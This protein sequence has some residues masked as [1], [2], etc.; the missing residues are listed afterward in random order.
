MYIY[1]D[2]KAERFKQQPTSFPVGAARQQSALE[3]LDAP[4]PAAKNVFDQID[5]VPDAP[6]ARKPLSLEEAD[7]LAP[8]T[9]PAF[10][11]QAP[12]PADPALEEM[13][14]GNDIAEDRL[15]FEQLHTPSSLDNYVDS[16]QRSDLIWLQSLQAADLHRIREIYE[17][18]STPP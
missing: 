7:R 8:A 4:T 18:H 13:R 17:Q 3:F 14:R 10:Q 6:A 5:F 11:Y 16:Q 1:N 2:S 9:P 12:K 15:L